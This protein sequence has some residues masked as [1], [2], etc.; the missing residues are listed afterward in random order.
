MQLDITKSSHMDPSCA[1]S[2]IQGS[3]VHMATAADFDISAWN[4]GVAL[5]T[6]AQNTAQ[7]GHQ[8]MEIG[9]DGQGCTQNG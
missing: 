2:T 8:L 9:C 5:V 1:F 3:D 6:L 7:V 4:Q